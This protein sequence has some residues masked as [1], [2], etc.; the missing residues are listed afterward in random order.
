M[1]IALAQ[2]DMRLGDI[3]G[4]C[5][6]I[7]SQALLAREQDAR[8]LCVPAPLFGGTA[9]GMLAESAG[10]V[11]DLL[12]AL[13]KLAGHCERLGI[14]ALVPAVVSH[15]DAPI[16]ELFMLKKGRVVPVRTLAAL[17]RGRASEELW[18]PVVFDVDG[19]RLAVT[20]D[21]QR[22]L[23]ELP[24][25][26]D[27]LVYF[28]MVPFNLADEATAAVAAVAD[29]HYREQVAR[30]GLWFACMA[31][32][33]GFDDAVFTGGSFVMDDSGRVVAAAPCFEEALLVQEISRGVTV[34]CLEGHELPHYERNEWLWEALRL[35]LADAVDA[36]GSSRIA[37]VLAGDLPSSLAAALAVDA[38]GPRN[39]IGLFIARQRIVTPSQ[40]AAE[41][42]RAQRVRDLA[43][44]LGIRLVE[45]IE[46]DATLVLDRDAAAQLGN[47]S[48]F[49]RLFLA[50]LAREEGAV[51]VSAITKTHVALAPT[52]IEGALS[53]E[54][55]PFGDV[56][57]TAL[58]FLARSR[59]RAGEVVPRELVSLK[60]VAMSMS[61]IVAHAVWSERA[62]PSYAGKMAELLAGLEPSQIDGV[63]EAHID[64]GLSLDEIPLATSEP[65]ACALLLML[66]RRGE[67]A[68]RAL[69]MAFAVSACSFEVRAWPRGL[70]WSDLG[71]KGAEQLTLAAVAQ[72]E[73]E[74]AESRGA[75]MNARMRSELMSLI[76]GLLGISPEQLE[77]LGT[78]EG[79]RRL[80][81]GIARFESHMQEVFG[82]MAED[83]GYDASDDQTGQ[84][85]PHASG[86]RGFPFFSLN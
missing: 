34:P 57:L 48:A 35:G 70:A 21:A 3:E 10:Y 77:E 62:E 32:V 28:Q 73:I 15:E 38:L 74:R 20:F 5:S 29:G 86:M 27:V 1:K 47:S 75:E 11:H 82:Q 43:S 8:L 17:R 40:E 16:L 36:L 61:E 14:T 50:D 6:R 67:P 46:P 9:P 45:R 23:E 84:I 80:G 66:V 37:L 12:A 41:A 53:G 30:R 31:P 4:I 2:I 56:Y 24:Q 79:Q 22:D 72:A 51:P 58:E 26:V 85:P 42:V 76:S 49:D 68:R 69:P 19:V 64:R 18:R 63:L 52:M 44:H 81:E 25:G 39:V 54:V 65:E 78:E 59:N 55:A 83:G 7:E 33:G 13:S 60:A 71:R